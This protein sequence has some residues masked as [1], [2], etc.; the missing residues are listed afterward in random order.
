MC[1]RVHPKSI[2][3]NSLQ[4]K[5]CNK[6][7]LMMYNFSKSKLGLHSALLHMHKIQCSPKGLVKKANCLQLVS[8]CRQSHKGCDEDPLSGTFCLGPVPCI[9]VYS[10]LL[11]ITWRRESQWSIWETIK[12]KKKLTNAQQSAGDTWDHDHREPIHKV[13][14]YFC[15]LPSSSNIQNISR[16][17][18]IHLV[19]IIFGNLGLQVVSIRDPTETS[20]PN[21]RWSWKPASQP[22]WSSYFFRKVKPLWRSL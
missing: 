7:L 2:S 16:G 14:C 15:P 21:H 22:S 10:K 19:H 18:K 3:T 8:T 4:Q 12:A 5:N 9:K 13:S 6:I 17:K 20:N 1:T 11:S